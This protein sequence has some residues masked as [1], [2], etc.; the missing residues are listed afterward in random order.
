MVPGGPSGTLWPMMPGG[1]C[2]ICRG[3]RRPMLVCG[4][5]RVFFFPRKQQTSQQVIS[6]E[7]MNKWRSNKRYK[8]QGNN[9]VTHNRHQ[10]RGANDA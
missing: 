5:V 1:P 7:E 10:A 3:A 2:G 4:H 6:E 9:K 8:C